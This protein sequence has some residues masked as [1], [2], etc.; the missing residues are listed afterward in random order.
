MYGAFLCIRILSSVITAM[1]H[2][3]SEHLAQIQK[4]VRRKSNKQIS[5]LNSKY[6][7]KSPYY[8][9]GNYF[10]TREDLM[11]QDMDSDFL[12]MIRQTVIAYGEIVNPP[13]IMPQNISVSYVML[14]HN[15]LLI[16]D[17]L[18]NSG[19]LPIHHHEESESHDLYS[20][21]SG[22]LVINKETYEIQ[23]VVIFSG[24]MRVDASDSDIILPR[25]QDDM[26]NYEI[27][28]HTHP[29]MQKY[30]GRLSE[31][32]VYEIPSCDD[33]INF[34]NYYNQG[35]LQT[36][37]VVAPEGLYVVRPVIITNH[38]PIPEGWVEFLRKLILKLE[39]KALSRL[40][41]S[42]MIDRLHEPS[43]FLQ[44]IANDYRIIRSYNRHLATANIFIE[45]YPRYL[46]KGMLHLP[47]IGVQYFFE[48]I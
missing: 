10:W 30:A 41:S 22:A 1:S 9:L 28:F 8:L 23:R 40:K 48:K 4:I 44:L 15:T 2:S 43:V 24:D 35:M 6:T 5:F 47:E 34:V 32:I 46:R 19:S 21:Y 38:I 27:F 11:P 26:L 18:F 20:E 33:I 29:N 37:I 42:E 16:L 12:E 31:G 13:W 14:R 3:L 7:P 36:S 39:S 45:Y 25:N 17:T